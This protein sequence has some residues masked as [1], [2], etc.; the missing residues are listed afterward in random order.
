M[1]QRKEQTSLVGGVLIGGLLGI[2]MFIYMYIYIHN[3]ILDG[4]CVLYPID[5]HGIGFFREMGVV[6]SIYLYICLDIYL[7]IWI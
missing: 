1:E 5:V 7:S 3:S 2:Y 4:F 6:L